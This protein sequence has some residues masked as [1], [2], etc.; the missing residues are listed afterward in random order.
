MGPPTGLYLLLFGTIFGHAWARGNGS[1]GVTMLSYPNPVDLWNSGAGVGIGPT[2]VDI[3]QTMRLCQGIGY[4]QMRLPNLLGHDTVSEVVLQAKYWVALLNLECQ[5]DTQ[6]FLC[7]LF[8]PVCLDRPI[9]PCRGLCEA[10][11]AGC[12]SRMN[13][14]GYPW[15][16]MVRC[17]KFPVD[18]DMCISVQ[19]TTKS[20]QYY[21]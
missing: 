3:P 7:S 12:E 18:N 9:Y 2:C 4:R 10:V 15:P 14:Y 21:I 1:A 5:P 11:R 20:G 17:D 16:D 6:L 13:E 19:T 8:S